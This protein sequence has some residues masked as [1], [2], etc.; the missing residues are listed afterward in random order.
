MRDIEVVE[1]S[2]DEFEALRLCDYEGLDQSEAGKQM[3][4]SRGTVQRLLYRARRQ[5]VGALL[6]KN[7]LAV[8]LEEREACHEG[9]HTHPRRRGARRRRV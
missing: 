4:I 3:G 6:N 1:I 2:L 9:M 7:A 5:V 8:N